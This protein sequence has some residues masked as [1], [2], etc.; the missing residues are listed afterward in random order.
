[1]MNE[2]ELKKL[3][4]KFHDQ[5][6]DDG[7]YTHT[8]EEIAMLVDAGYLS[9]MKKRNRYEITHKLWQAVKKSE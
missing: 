4:I 8:Q 5:I 3:A 7:A 6:V 2:D 1:M 9:A